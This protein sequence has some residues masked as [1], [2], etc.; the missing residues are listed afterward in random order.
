[1]ITTDR[2]RALAAM[3]RGER[4]LNPKIRR[5]R[6]GIAMWP[7][8][9]TPADVDQRAALADQMRAAA[10]IRVAAPLTEDEKSSV[11]A[12]QK[13]M[14]DAADKIDNGH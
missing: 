8:N 11:Y 10:R 2:H 3:A 6:G 7:K 1:M 4:E 14:R 9:K 12:A 13:A 5:R